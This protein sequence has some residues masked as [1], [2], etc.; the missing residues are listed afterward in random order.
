MARYFF[1]VHDVIFVADDHGIELQGLVAART[2]AHRLLAELAAHDRPG[3]NRREIR[4]AVRDETGALVLS[5]TLQMA[6]ELHQS[7][8]N[9]HWALPSAHLAREG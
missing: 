7:Q 5:A 6:S 2:E 3:S 9:G 8:P 1:D 4:T